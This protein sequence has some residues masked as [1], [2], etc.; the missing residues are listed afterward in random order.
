VTVK[1][2]AI[3]TRIGDGMRARAILDFPPESEIHSQSR[4]PIHTIMLVDMAWGG[5][6]EA[7]S[8]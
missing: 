5:R 4:R 8:G 2:S 3:R 1:R 6:R 7:F